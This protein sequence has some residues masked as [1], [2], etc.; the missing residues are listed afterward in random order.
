MSVTNE[1]D[2]IEYGDVFSLADIYE[3]P[4]SVTIELGTACNLRCMHCYIPNHGHS[5]LSIETIEQIFHQLREL[6]TFELVLTGGEIFC[7]R[8]GLQIVEMARK[9]GFD[10]IV[11]TNASLIDENCAKRLSQLYVGMVSTSIYSINKSVHDG[12]TGCSGSLD[13]TLKGLSYLKKYG[14]PVE[15]KT[16]IMQQN[17]QDLAE[18]YSYCKD[19]GFGCVASPFIFCMSDKNRR[20]LSLRVSGEELKGIIPLLNQIVEFAPQTRKQDDYICPSMRHS[21][22]IDASGD[23]FP[24]NAM[25]HKIGSIYKTSL[26]DIWFSDEAKRIR[27]LRYRDLKECRTCKNSSYCIRCA[28]I[29]L[30]E[31]GDML[32]KFD[33]ACEVAGARAKC[34]G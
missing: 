27:N 31:N 34:D 22:G 19:N 16:M 33:Y 8:D 17:Y 12:I 25:F 2:N 14:V 26:R 13:A 3:I 28:G 18:V 21:F 11:F 5:E 9:M 7:R 15:V 23:V 29:A 24:C 6:G 32:S 1:F 4:A 20:P 30:G 10:V